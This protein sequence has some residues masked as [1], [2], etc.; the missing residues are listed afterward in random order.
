M[1]HISLLLFSLLTCSSL[2][3]YSPSKVVFTNREA[4]FVLNDQARIAVGPEDSL[5]GWKDGSIVKRVNGVGEGDFNLRQQT[6]LNGTKYE[7]TTALAGGG[8]VYSNSNAINIMDS[9]N[10]ELVINNSNAIVKLNR[11][12]SD[13]QQFVRHN[14]N[15][16]EYRYRTMSNAVNYLVGIEE[17]PLVVNAN[18]SIDNIRF[19]KNG[20]V[21]SDETTLTINTPL[22][23]AGGVI[24]G[25][26][27]ALNING[28]LTLSSNAYFVNDTHLIGQNRKLTLQNSV[29]FNNALQLTG[30]LVIDGCG[31]DVFI[32]N[33]V[34]LDNF[35]SVTFRNMN[36]HVV[37]DAYFS[38]GEVSHLTLQNVQVKLHDDCSFTQGYLHIVDDVIVRGKG[39]SLAYIS[40]KPLIV[41]P[42]ALLKFEV[43]TT[44]ILGPSTPASRYIMRM[45]DPT[46]LLY[47]NGSTFEASIDGAHITHGTVLFDNRV[48]VINKDGVGDNNTDPNKAI[49][50]ETQGD[51]VAHVHLL[52]GARVEVDGYVDFPEIF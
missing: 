35:A 32:N 29:I 51:S 7:A 49:T 12:A 43:D 27:A 17:T 31:N 2:F 28:D 8:L 1:K 22:S 30:G 10:S 38:A 42:G 34:L 41:H 36:M 48:H 19:I 45:I 52:A 44:F 33:H 25:E 18:T 23:L 15:A 21:I 26:N 9:S 14:S 13:L 24:F 6:V 5:L 37:E 39:H 50:F 11:T 4:A 47:F 40:S 20:I 16:L 46:S 3:S